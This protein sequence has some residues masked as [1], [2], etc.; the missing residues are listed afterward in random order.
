MN[1]AYD[2]PDPLKEPWVV[3]RAY[4]TSAVGCYGWNVRTQS[5]SSEVEAR[6]AHDAPLGRGELDTELLHWVAD[7]NHRDGLRLDRVNL[8]KR[9]KAR[10]S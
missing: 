4:Q 5:Y 10:S 7:P 8:R 6:A 1:R 2:R 3:R 9:K